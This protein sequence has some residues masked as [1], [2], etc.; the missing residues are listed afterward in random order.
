MAWRRRKK[1]QALLLQGEF[2]KGPDRWVLPC[3]G[4]TGGREGA[5]VA[6]P[7]ALVSQQRGQRLTCG[8]GQSC[9]TSAQQGW[10]LETLLE[11]Q[12]EGGS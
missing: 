5:G 2:E 7:E 9:G 12:G 8:P 11:R 1:G 3:R 10:W 6:C 4:R